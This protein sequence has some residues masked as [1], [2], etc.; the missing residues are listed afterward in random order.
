MLKKYALTEEHLRDL[1]WG[2]FK[3]ARLEAAFRKVAQSEIVTPY[4]AVIV[5]SRKVYKL[6]GDM[7]RGQ[8][9]SAEPMIVL[10]EADLKRL[11]EKGQINKNLHLQPTAQASF[12]DLIGDLRSLFNGKATSE[13]WTSL[14][15]MFD[16]CLEHEV[17]KLAEYSLAQLEVWSAHDM[18]G[19]SIKK[20]DYLVHHIELGP[21]L[22]ALPENQLYVAPPRWIMDMAQGKYHPKHQV[23]RVLNLH[24]MNIDWPIMQTIL[25][26]PYLCNITHLNLG[27]NVS[28]CANRAF[29][30]ALSTHPLMENLK[31]LTIY[32]LT[33]SFIRAIRVLRRCAPFE[34]LETLNIHYQPAALD[35]TQILGEI[36]AYPCFERAQFNGMRT[37]AFLVAYL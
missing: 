10:S 34:S 25:A 24:R 27:D 15:H 7:V 9:D 17:D 3:D 23:V 22:K 18:P 11:L 37:D 16:R 1:S 12:D 4:Y 14:L 8:I 6:T 2:N 28:L 5:A 35:W 36:Q 29:Y 26:N 19:W 30:E 33:S 32:A 31:E 20:Q 21:W 13:K